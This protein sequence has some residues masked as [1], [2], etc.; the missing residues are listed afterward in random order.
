MK[1]PPDMNDFYL[2]FGELKTFRGRSPWKKGR[3]AGQVAEAG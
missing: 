2:E 3:D 1:N